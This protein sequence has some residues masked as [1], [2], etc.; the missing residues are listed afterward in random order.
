MEKLAVVNPYAESLSFLDGKTRT[1]RDHMKYL[2]LIRAV[3][4]LHQHQREIK[5]V[6]HRGRPVRYVEASIADIALAN[7]LAHETLGH[8]LDELPPQ[9]RTLLNALD[10]WTREQCAVRQIRRSDWR[11]TRR[12]VRELTGWGDTQA[13]V[14]LAR[15][16]ELEYLLA[17]RLGARFDYELIYDGEGRNGER[18]A[19]GLCEIDAESYAHGAAWSGRDDD[20][21]GPG[22]GPVG[23]SRGAV[24]MRKRPQTLL[25]SAL[26]TKSRRARAKRIS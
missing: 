6:I 10:A 17:H 14:H 11:F 26:W 12:E 8:T 19:L 7:K 23:P 2:T 21:A 25:M 13:K 5:T 1:R 3:T 15:L 18:F 24:G 4:L 22:R 9:T 16:V 20:R